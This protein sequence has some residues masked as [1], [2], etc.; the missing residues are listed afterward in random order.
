MATSKPDL[1][2]RALS[3]QYK[4]PE[5]TNL[6]RS[7]QDAGITKIHKLTVMSRSIHLA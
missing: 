5:K 6:S 2:T 7:V 4:R 3:Y 1:L